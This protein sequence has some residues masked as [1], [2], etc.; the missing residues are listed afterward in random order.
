MTTATIEAP[1]RRAGVR[2]VPWPVLVLGGLILARLGLAAWWLA[3]D[4][5]VL[6]TESGRHVQRAW[7]GYNAMAAGDTFAFFKTPTEYPPLHYLVA[8]AGALIGGLHADSLVAAQDVFAIPALTLG[9]Y[10]AA[11]LSYGRTAGV[12][13]AVFALGTP[14]TASVFHMFLIDTTEAAAAALALWGILACD[15]FSRVGV[16]ALAGAAVGLG[17]LS[18]QNFPLFV[19]GPLLVV[20]LR[21]GWRHWRGLLVFAAVAALLTATWYWSEITRTLDLVRGASGEPAGSAAPGAATPIRWTA[22]NLGWY[23]WS[24]LDVSVLVPLALAAAAGGVAVS[25]RWLRTRAA[26]DRTLE[27]VAGALVAY[28]GLTWIQLKDPRY[29][30]PLLPYLAV[31]AG[32]GVAMLRP[33]R[34]TVAIAAVAVVA[35]VNVVGTVT[36]A[37]SAVQIDLPG[38]TPSNMRHVGLYSPGGWITGAPE[39]SGAIPAVMR[40][41]KSG[42]IEKIAFDPGAQQAHFNHPGL[43]IVSRE[44]GIPIAIPFDP[45]DPRQAMISNHYPPLAGTPPCGVLD[46]GTGIYL[47]RGSIAVPYEQRHFLCPRH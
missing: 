30:L 29:A 37:G 46:D 40:A 36:N 28:A 31:L 6:D 16:S 14:I 13:A 2:S 43:D 39:T 26:A 21:G 15:R 45:A 4:S 19:A 1:S 18:K 44:V 9:C 38:A 42:G 17:M 3:V 5:G 35:L 23:A 34:Q 20:L 24:L 41:A 12:V 22:K 33:R 25:V 8:S 10:G 27:L 11:S 7:D 47:S 32:G